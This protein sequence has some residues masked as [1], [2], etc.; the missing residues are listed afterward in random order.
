M[1]DDVRVMSRGMVTRAKHGERC[2]YVMRGTRVVGFVKV[3][4]E[5]GMAWGWAAY[6]FIDPAKGS[7]EPGKEDY[8]GAFG[9]MDEAVAKVGGA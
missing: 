5:D 8:L 9:T 6:K 2:E 4:E 1:A 3:A 7:A